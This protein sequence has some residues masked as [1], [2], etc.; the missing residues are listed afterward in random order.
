MSQQKAETKSLE[1]A[2]QY[3]YINE[4][5]FISLIV[6][7]FAGEILTEIS[8]RVGLFYWVLMVPIFMAS[9]L[10]SE[11][12]KELKTGEKT[13]NAIKYLL[14]YWGS[15]F[16]AVLLVF[17]IWHGD[18]ISPQSGALVIH[19][20]LAHTMLLSGI[21]LGLRFYLVGVFLFA[22][23]AETILL[24]GAF[25]VDLAIMIPIIWGGLYVERR[26]L[27]PIIRKTHQTNDD[28]VSKLK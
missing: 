3:V 18:T 7:C 16:I 14:I 15:A 21:E 9:S 10:F 2:L 27:F 8:E 28:K 22:T 5:I 19:I 24:E 11:K 12:A 6:L 17:L 4:V 13:K 20:I 25:A 26:Y 1:A 23:A